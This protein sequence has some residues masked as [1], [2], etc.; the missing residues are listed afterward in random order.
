MG[1]ALDWLSDNAWLPWL[2]L[3]LVLGIVETTTLD[4]VFLMLAG[5]AVG[6]AVAG[7]LGAPFIVQALVAIATSAALL[8]V[9]RPVAKRHL[10][11]P[12]GARTGVAAL[13]GRRA[14]VVE[15]VDAHGGRVKLAGEIWSARSYDH[16]VIEPGASVDVVEIQGA[17]ALVYE[18][19]GP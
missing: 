3:A 18:A 2:G 9:V 19:E 15:R 13:V 10:R 1:D 8:G 16:S 17:T 11:Q 14:I 5:G 7:A 4:L 12:V 6:G